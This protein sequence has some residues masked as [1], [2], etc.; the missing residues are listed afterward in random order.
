MLSAMFLGKTRAGQVRLSLKRNFKVDLI[1]GEAA[2]TDIIRVGTS[3]GGARPK[4][5]IAFNEK[6]QEIRSG[7]VDAPDGFSHWLLKIDG[8]QETGL[9]Q[10]KD[11]GR[12]EY[13]YHLM[14]K[15]C[16][17]NAIKTITSRNRTN[18]SENGF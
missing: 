15:D 17:I 8:V 3:A 2:I 6:T 16:G 5:V 4:A 7:Q 10:T 18:V 14:A 11:V 12:I 13:A 1:D 9:G